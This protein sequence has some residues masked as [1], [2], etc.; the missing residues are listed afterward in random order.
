MSTVIWTRFGNKEL[1]EIDQ[2]VAHLGITRAAFI[3][4]A[5]LLAADSINKHKDRGEDDEDHKENDAGP[6]PSTES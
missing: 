3:R 1:A 6:S 4:G 5:V 2:V